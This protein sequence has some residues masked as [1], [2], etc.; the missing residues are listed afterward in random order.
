MFRW[1]LI[2]LPLTLILGGCATFNAPDSPRLHAAPAPATTPIATSPTA[3]STYGGY[4]PL[5]SCTNAGCTLQWFDATTN[6]LAPQN[7][8]LHLGH[9]ATFGHTP[10]LSHLAVITYT[11][12]TALHAGELSFIDLTTLERHPTALTFDGATQPLHFSPDGAHLLV[13]TQTGTW[14]NTINALHLVDTATLRVIA[15][16]ELDFY[17][18]RHTFTTDNRALLLY[19]TRERTDD[20]ERGSTTHVARL[21][22]ATLAIEW[23][24][25]VN[26]LANGQTRPGGSPNPMDWVWWQPATAFAPADATLYIVHADRDALTTIDYAHQRIHTRAITAPMSQLERWLG[27]LLTFTAHPVAAKISNG[28]TK[29][30]VLAPD[31]TRL[32]LIGTQHSMAGTA[33]APE[34]VQT[35]LDL[36]VIDP[37]TATR[38]TTFPTDAQSL[39]L[40]PET[41]HLLLHGWAANQTKPYTNE[42]TTILDIA[43]LQTVA[44]LDQAVAS[45]RRLDGTPQL[46]AMATTA[47]RQVTLSLLDPQD[48]N[49]TEIATKFK[50]NYVGWLAL[51]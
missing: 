33:N 1:L 14:P 16:R 46:V 4:L 7:T 8:S 44:E 20:P 10:N 34:F 25:E 15:T 32:Y 19:G 12:N 17:P 28:V 2:Y 26:D 9:Y 50:A 38:H 39:T 30:A 13:I 40:V 23:Q 47:P 27:Q 21:N 5:Q 37:T 31:G 45:T 43:T 24:A 36:Q 6:E 51:P 41:E 22:A 29:Q 35:P 42:W 11:N 49:I 3:P 18:A 48:L